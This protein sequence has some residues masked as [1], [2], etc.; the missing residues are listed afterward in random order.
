MNDLLELV[1]FSLLCM[2]ALLLLVQ[3]D[4]PRNPYE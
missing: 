3:L 1:S 2:I 4:A